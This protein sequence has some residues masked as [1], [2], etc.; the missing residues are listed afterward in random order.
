M[1]MTKNTQVSLSWWPVCPPEWLPHDPLCTCFRIFNALSEDTNSMQ[2][3]LMLLLYSFS[4]I[5]QCREL[6]SLSFL[7]SHLSF[8]KVP[9]F[10]YSIMGGLQSGR[11]SSSRSNP[12]WASVFA[13]WSV[14]ASTSYG[15]VVRVSFSS[16]CSSSGS[17]SSS[18][19]FETVLYVVIGLGIL[20]SYSGYFERIFEVC[21]VLWQRWA[22]RVVLLFVCPVFV[23]GY[24]CSVFL[25]PRPG[26]FFLWLGSRL[27]RGH[28]AKS[29]HLWGFFLA[30][31]HRTATWTR[32]GL[33]D[34]LLFFRVFLCFLREIGWLLVVNHWKR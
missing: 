15:G 26:L 18:S 34:R 14:L 13:S 17:M 21:F 8:G 7:L 12:W 32:A 30:Q 33:G 25:F 1:F 20:Y 27:R 31:T 29:L 6:R 9:F 22:L 4:L 23:E 2:G 3:S 28:S 19:S 10:M 24:L 16:R 11:A 5:I